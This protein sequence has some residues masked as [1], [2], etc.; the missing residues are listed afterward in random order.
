MRTIDPAELTRFAAE[1]LAAA[2][3]ARDEAAVVAASLVG[4]NLR[5]HDSHGVMRL[6]QYVGF[7]E[8]GE[9]RHGVD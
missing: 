7:I 6:P 1:L 5:G 3:V 8:R 2:G 9:Y 4:A